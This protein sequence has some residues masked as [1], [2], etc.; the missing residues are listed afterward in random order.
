MGKNPTPSHQKYDFLKNLYIYKIKLL[1]VFGMNT[2]VL[3]CGC[4]NSGKTTTI[5]KFFRNGYVSCINRFRFYHRVING[6]D[7]YALSLSS[8]QERENFCVVDDVKDNISFRMQECGKKAN[9]KPHILVIP[10]G[11]YEDEKREKLNENCFLEPI[12]WLRVEKG[13][14][15]FPWYL[16]KVNV[17]KG[18]QKDALARKVRLD[19]IDT[20]DKDFDKSNELEQI[21]KRLIAETN[22]SPDC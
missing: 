10:Y 11:I 12:E 20:T 17:T 5:E 21:V 14:K 16:R 13:F 19:E 7:V 1:L 2:I 4:N 6:I 22:L 15:V 8:P 9:G 3:V 18:S